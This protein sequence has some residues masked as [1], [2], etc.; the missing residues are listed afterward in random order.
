MFIRT[1]NPV[2][3]LVTCAR[4]VKHEESTDIDSSAT[5]DKEGTTAEML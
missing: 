4:F 1:E 5:N 3:Y 2:N